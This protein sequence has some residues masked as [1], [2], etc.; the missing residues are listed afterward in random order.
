LALALLHGADPGQLRRAQE[1]L[2]QRLLGKALVAE[3]ERHLG[4]PYVWGGKDEKR[5][6]GLDC[7]GFTA[8]VYASQGIPLAGTAMGQYQGGVAIEAPA[9]SPGDLVFFLSSSAM[10]PMHVGIYVGKGRFIHAPSEGKTIR[11]ESMSKPYFANR[12]VGAR[13]YAPPV[14]F[15]SLGGNKP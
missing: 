3:A 15:N 13:R 10:T 6:G 1:E 14:R 7:S 12:Y 11:F 2:R 9:L 4:A 5:D 8:L